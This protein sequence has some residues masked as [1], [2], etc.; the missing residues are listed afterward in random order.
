MSA[1]QDLSTAIFRSLVQP[2][3]HFSTAQIF[4]IFGYKYKILP[5]VTNHAIV[6]NQKMLMCLS[7]NV[8]RKKKYT[9]RKIG[10]M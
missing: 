8:N 7:S 3:S 10:C 5:K 1:S 9:K 6:F 2:R 4:V